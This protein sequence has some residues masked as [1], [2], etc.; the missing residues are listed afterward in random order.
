MVMPPAWQFRSAQFGTDLGPPNP[1]FYK[2]QPQ[3][4][5]DSWIT[6]GKPPR[7]PSSLTPNVCGQAGGRYCSPRAR[8]LS[9]VQ[10]KHQCVVKACTLPRT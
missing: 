9:F 1:V 2:I 8:T 6:I 4:K 5:F 10:T 7:A 3:L